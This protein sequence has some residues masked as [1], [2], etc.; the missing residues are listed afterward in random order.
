MK[1]RVTACV[2]I[3]EDPLTLTQMVAVARKNA[4]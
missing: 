1:R 2:T 3:G 4:G